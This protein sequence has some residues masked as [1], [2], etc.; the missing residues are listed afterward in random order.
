M[1]AYWWRDNWIF[2]LLG[3]ALAALVAAVVWDTQ[4]CVERGPEERGFVMMYCG[5]GCFTA[6]PTTTRRC[7]RR[8]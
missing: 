5:K 8:R 1:R 3:A 7:V 6:V 4:T 2:V